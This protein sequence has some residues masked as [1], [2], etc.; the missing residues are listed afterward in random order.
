MRGSSSRKKFYGLWSILFAMYCLGCIRPEPVPGNYSGRFSWQDGL[1]DVSIA[2]ESDGHRRL[3]L[4]NRGIREQIESMI[5]EQTTRANVP[6]AQGSITI[7]I[8]GTPPVLVSLKHFE[9]Q[10]PNFSELLAY[11]ESQNVGQVQ[12]FIDLHH[13]ANQ[14]DLPSQRTALFY[15]AA[16]SRVK[17][18]RV[19]LALGSDPNIPDFEG[20]TPLIAAVV[21]NCD[22]AARQLILSGAN[23]NQADQ[24]GET[25]LIRAVE[26]GRPK[27]LTLLLRSGADP[28]Y[29][30]PSGE[31]A[32][33]IARDKRDRAAIGV[34]RRFG[35]SK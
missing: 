6:T 20:D 16:G 10:V 12:Q 24:K 33:R 5:Q 8:S 14:R 15:A 35:A 13:N 22:E 1:K 29:V 21:A 30:S 4:R 3:D 25:P 18:A 11:V 27:L 7:S 23:V 2:L 32:L 17:A 9:I 26:L 28:N 31:S 19:L 34:L